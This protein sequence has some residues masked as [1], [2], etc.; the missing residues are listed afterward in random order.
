LLNCFCVSC[1][2]LTNQQL[3]KP[4]RRQKQRQQ[5]QQEKTLAPV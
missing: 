2:E 1:G 4:Q 3:P 5:A